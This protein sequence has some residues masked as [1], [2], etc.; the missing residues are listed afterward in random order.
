MKKACSRR[1][2]WAGQCHPSARRQLSCDAVLRC[3]PSGAGASGM[4][5]RD[6]PSAPAAVEALFPSVQS[7]REQPRH[8]SHKTARQHSRNREQRGRRNH[9][10]ERRWCRWSSHRTSAGSRCAGSNRAGSASCSSCRKAERSN[11]AP[12][13]S[14]WAP[15]RHSRSS[16][17]KQRSRRPPPVSCNRCCSRSHSGPACVATA[18]NRSSGRIGRR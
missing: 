14:N 17:Q 4:T 8:H 3:S 1:L 9:S 10:R 2:F 12:E 11:S 18:R 7:E 15:Q 5:P 16:E 6:R 13:C